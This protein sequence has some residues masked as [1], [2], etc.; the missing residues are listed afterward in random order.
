[1]PHAFKYPLRFNIREN[2][3][4]IIQ[5]KQSHNNRRAD[6]LLKYSGDYGGDDEQDR[7]EIGQDVDDVRP[8]RTPWYRKYDI[9]APPFQ[10]PDRF[11]LRKTPVSVGIQF[12]FYL[13]D[14]FVIPF[15][16]HL[17]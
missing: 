13:F 7:G 4:G 1:M 12:Y 16:V 9:P 17:F 11:F 10:P 2:R 3:D 14:S 15:F 6:T 5:K 8:E